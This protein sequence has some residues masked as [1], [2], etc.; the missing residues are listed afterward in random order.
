MLMLRS[1]SCRR[2]TTHEDI[3]SLCR[4]AIMGR[5]AGRLNRGRHNGL[6]FESLLYWTGTLAKK[7]G[8]S[9]PRGDPVP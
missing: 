4:M 3:L 9:P 5:N 8:V 2:M 6:P 7:V 1:E